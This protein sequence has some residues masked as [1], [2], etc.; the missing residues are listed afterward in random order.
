MQAF[1]QVMELLL[2][3]IWNQSQ[4]IQSLLLSLGLLN[5]Q[6]DWNQ[7]QE[8]CFSTQ[9]I[10]RD[11]NQSLLKGMY[12]ELLFRWKR[13]ILLMYRLARMKNQR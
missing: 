5:G 12:L 10:I 2:L 8:I 13:H 4:R 11:K 3:K 9:S 7:E 6:T 1:L